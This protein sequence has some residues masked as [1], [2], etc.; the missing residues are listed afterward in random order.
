MHC[1]HHEGKDAREKESRDGVSEGQDEIG[2]ERGGERNQ[3]RWA[4]T[5]QITKPTK[6]RPTQQHGNSKHCLHVTKDNRVNAKVLRQKLKELIWVVN[7]F[8]MIFDSLVVLQLVSRRQQNRGRWLCALWRSSSCR[9][10][11]RWTPLMS[12]VKTSCQILPRYP[13]SVSLP[14]QLQL[15]TSTMQPRPPDTVPGRTYVR[16]LEPRPLRPLRVWW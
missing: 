9:V 15:S 3:E 2:E 14:H 5:K 1:M 8:I 12:S 4:S 16:M 11:C 13:E 6:E 10:D 7:D